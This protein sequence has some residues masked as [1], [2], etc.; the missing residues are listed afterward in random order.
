MPRK[1]DPLWFR[2]LTGSIAVVGT[3]ALVLYAVRIAGALER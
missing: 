2:V 3:A 1:P